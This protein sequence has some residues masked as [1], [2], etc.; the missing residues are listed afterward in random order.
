MISRDLT[1]TGQLHG[2]PEMIFDLVADMP[3]Y[4]RWLSNSSAFGGTVDLTPYPLRFGTTHLDAGPVLKAGS[5]REFDR[6]RHLSFRNTAQIR[7]NPLNTNVDARIRYIFDPKKGGT[8]LDRRPVV[9]RALNRESTTECFQQ[10]FP[11]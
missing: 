10:L 3:D 7:Q 4:D 8:L 6:P 5:V 2:S 11:V 1:F 9:A